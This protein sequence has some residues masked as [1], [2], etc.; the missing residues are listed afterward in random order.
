[1][2]NKNM[3][4]AEKNV[5]G[6]KNPNMAVNLARLG[7]SFILYAMVTLVFF[8]AL[9][10]HVD[11]ALLGPPEDNLQDLWNSWY[12]AAG[13]LK[14]L[15]F[16]F[17]DLIKFPEGTT[18]YYHS[19]AYPQVFLVWLGTKLIG[20]SLSALLLLQNLVILLSFPLAGTG[21][22]ALAY[23]STRN[24]W[25]ALLGGFVFAFNPSHLEH[26]MH[27]LH[28]ASIGFIPFFVLC[29][30]LALEKRSIVWLTVAIMFYALS[31]LSCWYYLFYCGY[32]VAFHT[33]YLWV[34]NRALLRGWTLYAPFATMG[35]VLIVLSPWLIPM[36]R[37]AVSG[38][39]VYE[40]G[41]DIF[42]ADILAYVTFPPHHVFAA[43]T[44]P[45]Y[46]HFGPPWA[47]NWEFTVYLGIPVI[48][49]FAW[50]LVNRH[51]SDRETVV[52]LAFAIAVFAAL[53]SGSHLHFLGHPVLP[54]PDLVLSHIPFF[55]NVRTPSRA[56]VF[57]Y[58][59]LAMAVSLAIQL[60]ARRNDKNPW[61]KRIAITGI[62]ILI[63][64]DFYPARLDL[65]TFSCSPGLAIVRDDPEQGFG[66]LNLPS[67][68]VSGNA[69][70]A[71]QICHE[72]P[73]VRGNT[74]R[75]IA[76]TLQ[77]F[78]VT[79]DLQTQRRQ[80]LNNRVKY[81]VLRRVENNIY[82]WGDD[83]DGVRDSYLK[84]YQPVYADA[85]LIILRIY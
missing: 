44:E 4:E 40:G 76:R 36:V 62:F 25:G 19:F 33:V 34:R 63:I 58:L 14:G 75:E 80:L 79:D 60:L 73:I 85:E 48:G 13:Y 47:G 17:T 42:V 77:N 3:G 20:T 32:F 7:G 84:T 72:R 15:S 30:L 50:L 65:T 2:S 64:A 29:Y 23:Y 11:S 39:N 66:V 57:V 10:P 51:S 18:L 43:L 28:V 54:M 1:M 81:I 69:D 5:G 82:D 8:W 12:A 22:F 55:R 46:R 56:I 9:L 61:V 83:K 26:S 78:L 41:S 53:A 37:E 38:A 49:L 59:F 68:Y 16:F 45:V 67:G 24:M 74:A 52:Y 27:H 35:G 70:M 6:A 21:A 71:E 31:A